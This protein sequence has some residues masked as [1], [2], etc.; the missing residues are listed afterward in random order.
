M[1][2]LFRV[3]QITARTKVYGI[4]GS[5]VTWSLSPVIHNRAFEER[6]LDAV[7]VPLQAEALE[8][9]P[10]RPARAPPLGLQRHAPVQDR[11]PAAPRR[12]S[13]DGHPR[14]QR[15]HRARSGRPPPRARPPTVS[16][17][18]A[19]P[20]EDR[21]QGPSVVILGAGGA[22]RAAALALL[23]EGARVT[24]L[25]R[26]PKQAA[27]VAHGRPAARRRP[28]ASSP[29]HAWDVLI[30]ATPVGSASMPRKTPGPAELLRRGCD[31]LR[32]GVRPARDA[33]PA[34][35]RGGRMRDRRRSR[36]CSWPRR[37]AQFETW[38]GLEAPLRGHEVGGPGGDPGAAARSARTAL[39]EPLL[40]A[41]AL[42]RASAREGQ[43]RLRGVARRSSSAAARSAPSSA[44]T[45]VARRR[46]RPHD[47][48]PR[49]RRALEPAA[50][51]A[52][53]GRGRARAACPRP[54]RPRR[55]CDASTP[56]SQVRG[57]VADVSAENV[58]EL[59]RGRRPR[60][61][62]HRQLRDA[63]PR[64][65]RVRR[66]RA[67]L[68]LRGLRRLV[69]PGAPGA[70]RRL[71]LPALCLGRSAAARS[72]PT[73]DTAGVVAPIVHVIA[74]IQA[75]EAL[76]V[77][78]GSDRVAPDG[79]R[80]RGPVGGLFEVM[81]LRGAGAVVSGLHRRPL[82]LRR[83]RRAGASAVLCGRDAVQV[84]AGR[85]T[86]RG[87]AGPRGAPA[88]AVG[89]VVANEY[90]VRFRRT[91][92]DLVVFARRPRHRQGRDATPPR[93]AP[94]TRSTWGAEP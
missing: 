17:S 29:S 88:R 90:L 28:G 38:T 63:L 69:R 9:V 86:P 72:G 5:D 26:N 14:G 33:P 94:S 32:H 12:R 67:P 89:S 76:K 50:A 48:G 11:D 92:A 75:G 6:G 78:R 58:D 45:M 44:E 35:G 71:A 18:S 55:S 1:A 54:R 19:P 43:E 52:L 22:A 2:D 4:L 34:R 20:Q 66:G 23:H 15:Q 84:R 74:G 47:R 37:S 62:R 41:G 59:V 8:P 40:A 70:A 7:Y 13:T 73:C 42:R 27:A 61:R 51:V 31:R 49:L 64:Q 56:T 21:D 60:P 85:G 83:L 57:L 81:D 77:L 93:P 68:G 91:D 87:P 16:A 80:H 65:R 25:A 36:R 24:V 10:R 30:N 46:R 3:R 82:R 39:R 53:R 79:N